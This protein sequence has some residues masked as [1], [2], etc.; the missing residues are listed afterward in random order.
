MHSCN[1]GYPSVEINLSKFGKG[2]F[3]SEDISE[4]TP[5]CSV[6]GQ[7][8]SFKETVLLGDRES[9]ALQV[10]LDKYILCEPPFLYSNHSC[11]P[12]CGLNS[13][14]EL[15]TLRHVK[16]GEELFWDYSTS[17]LERHWTMNCKCGSLRCRTTILDFDLLPVYQQQYYI[18]LNIVLP[19]IVNYL[20]YNVAI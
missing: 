8:I 19:F 4:G 6:K 14:L 9:H 2:L 5:V 15:F 16:K 11:E 13:D 7:S 20:T 12:N 3:A 10:H 18:K 1:S 17:M